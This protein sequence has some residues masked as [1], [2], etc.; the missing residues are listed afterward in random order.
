MAKDVSH[1]E[2]AHPMLAAAAPGVKLQTFSTPNRNRLPSRR[3][4]S[5][6]STFWRLV[7][8]RHAAVDL[9]KPIHPIEEIVVR[10]FHAL[11]LDALPA[12]LDPSGDGDAGSERKVRVNGPDDPP[13]ALHQPGGYFG[14]ARQ[15]SRRTRPTLF[16]LSKR[17]S[18]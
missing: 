13:R 7:E 16:T 18:V 10:E 2:Q 3:P 17:A 11:G 9:W 4:W 12:F 1:G 15:A 14:P 6:P 5:G 8:R